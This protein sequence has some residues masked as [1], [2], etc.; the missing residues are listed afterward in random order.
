[1]DIFELKY[2]L[3]YKIKLICIISSTVGKHFKDS[4]DSTPEAKSGVFGTE[5]RR[6]LH[7]QELSTGQGQSGLEF[8]TPH[9]IQ[10]VLG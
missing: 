1:V 6:T 5:A 9:F 3:V 7:L 2:T 8:V 10:C 4:A